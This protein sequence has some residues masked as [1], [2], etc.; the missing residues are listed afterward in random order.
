M[1]DGVR[2]VKG[3][4]LG[5][6]KDL[7]FILYEM[8]NIWVVG[9]IRFGIWFINRFILIFGLKE[10]WRVVRMKREVYFNYLGKW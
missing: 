8:E 10:N 5:R 4:I 9:M 2:E 1:G 3:S 7:I 6:C